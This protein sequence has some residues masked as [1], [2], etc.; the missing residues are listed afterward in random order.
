MVTFLER[1]RNSH[2]A[3]SRRHRF[4]LTD[5]TMNQNPAYIIILEPTINLTPAVCR[6]GVK[7]FFAVWLVREKNHQT[8]L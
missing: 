3:L 7:D 8:F 6:R 1:V 2:T 4:S 5:H